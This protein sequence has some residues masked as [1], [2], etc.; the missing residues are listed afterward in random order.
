M[1]VRSSYFNDNI[2]VDKLVQKV[3][4]IGDS[5]HKHTDKLVFSFA[6][7]EQYTKVKNKLRADNIKYRQ[8]G[9][10]SIYEI[11][12]RLSA[13][14]KQWGIKIATCGEAAELT[15]YGI[16]HNKCIDD[17]LLLDI[18]NNDHELMKLLGRTNEQGNLFNSQSAKIKSSKDP[19]QRKECLCVFS[20]DIG[21]YNTCPHLCSYCYANTSRKAVEQKMKEF[22]FKKR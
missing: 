18:S 13:L 19:G 4:Y 21:E 14:A 20:K 1:E 16:S 22:N 17:E 12:E 8:F 15:N 11:A 10:D 9:Q 2:S 5:I 3:E 7:I 6:D